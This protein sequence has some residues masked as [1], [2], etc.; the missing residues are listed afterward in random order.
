MSGSPDGEAATRTLSVSGSPDC[1]AATR[2]LAVSGSPDGAS[3]TRTLAVS[4]SPDGAAAT[5]TL[6]VS[7]SPDGAPWNRH[8][9]YHRNYMPLLWCG[10]TTITVTICHYCGVAQVPSPSINATIEVW[11]LY[12]YCNY[13]PL[14]RDT[15]LLSPSL[16]ATIQMHT[17]TITVN[18]CHY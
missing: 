17:T 4:G 18:I 16:Y 8:H 9:Y 12:Y 2:M 10:T 14:F 3:A 11:H 7:G 1:A 5:S 13:M 6:A 15:P